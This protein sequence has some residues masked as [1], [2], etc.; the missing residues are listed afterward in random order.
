MLTIYV[1]H[2]CLPFMFTIYVNHL[3]L[4]LT[5]TINAYNLCWPFMFT[6]YVYHLCWPF[7]LTIYV[8]HWRLPLC[9]PIMFTIY[10]VFFSHRM[11]AIQTN[12]LFFVFLPH[13]LHLQFFEK[14]TSNLQFPHLALCQQCFWVRQL[15][16]RMNGA[17]A[18]SFVRLV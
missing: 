15:Q 18:I 10:H 5:F 4:P 12:G 2:L 17:D 3:C 9:L 14:W 16:S 8:Y 7:M 11:F 13:F 1:D 6:I